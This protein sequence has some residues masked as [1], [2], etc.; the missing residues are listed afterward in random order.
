MYQMGTIITLMPFIAEFITP[1][2]VEWYQQ[3]IPENA[4]T[5]RFP[6]KNELEQALDSAFPDSYEFDIKTEFTWRINVFSALYRLE[7]NAHFEINLQSESK[8][9]VDGNLELIVP[10]L[11]ELSVTC[12]TFVVTF[13]G[14]DALFIDKNF[15]R[16]DGFH[17]RPLEASDVG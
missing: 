16:D 4:R 10:L 2:A 6:T 8:L 3:Y 17:D 14:E 1:N 7:I 15:D 13:N 5:G 12:G 11:E 9:Y